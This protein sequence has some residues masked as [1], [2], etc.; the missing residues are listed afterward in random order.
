METYGTF[1]VGQTQCIMCINSV[2]PHIGFMIGLYYTDEEM[3]QSG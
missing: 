2:Y 3:V 1:T